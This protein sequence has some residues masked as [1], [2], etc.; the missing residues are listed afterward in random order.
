MKVWI[1]ASKSDK[2]VS[3]FE[4]IKNEFEIAISPEESDMI[5]VLGG[6]GSMLEAIHTFMHLEKPF[7]GINCGSVGFLMNEMSDDIKS[8]ILIAENSIVH[9]LRVY[10]HDS[11]GEVHILYAIN[12]V[13]ITRGTS[14]ASKLKITVDEKVRLEELI[15][16][17]LI[18]STPVG[19]TAYNLSAGGPILPLESPLNILT[20][21]CA[22]RPRRWKGAIIPNSLDIQ[23]DVNESDRRAVNVTVDS[24]EVKNAVRVIVQTAEVPK[25]L[26]ACDKGRSWSDKLINEQFVY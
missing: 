9:P 1:E 7:Y 3:T 17:G 20:P 16:D 11:N 21:I 4:T 5:V 22:F 15:G 25:I 2:A 14:Q 23:I 13:A 19:S 8:K 12:D 6:D 26:I 24:Q 10:V 18:I